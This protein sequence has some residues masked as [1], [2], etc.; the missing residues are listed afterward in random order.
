MAGKDRIFTVLDCIYKNSHSR[1]YQSSEQEKL[2]SLLKVKEIDLLIILI[3]K[4]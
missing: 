2:F 1:D 4:L 3:L